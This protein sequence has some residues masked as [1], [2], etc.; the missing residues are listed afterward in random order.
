VPD[1]GTCDHAARRGLIAAGVPI[2]RRPPGRLAV[3]L[4]GRPAIRR[5]GDTRYDRAG[6]GG[7]RSR[8][9]PLAVEAAGP[10][11]TVRTS[12]RTGPLP[13]PRRAP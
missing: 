13:F 11:N 2:L 5:R 1:R 9:T 8:R 12:G 6:T 7:V 10:R 4:R 3:I